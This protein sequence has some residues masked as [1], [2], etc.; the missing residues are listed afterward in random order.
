M[1][2]FASISINVLIIC[3]MYDDTES[4][5]NLLIIFASKSDVGFHFNRSIL[6]VVIKRLNKT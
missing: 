4:W 6:L 3:C 1:F 2:V 5:I